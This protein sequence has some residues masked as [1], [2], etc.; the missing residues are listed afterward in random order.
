MIKIGVVEMTIMMIPVII[1]AISLGPVAGGILGGVFGLLSF[2]ECFGKSA[3]GVLL[4][5]I[6]PWATALMCI[7][8]RVLAGMLTGLIF[9]LLKKVD[10]TK[11]ISFGVAGLSGA[12]L[13]TLFFMGSLGLLFWN[14]PEFIS[15]MQS[16]QIPTDNFF[17]LCAAM[18]GTNGII[19]AIVCFVTGSAIAKAVVKFINKV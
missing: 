17:V 14:S 11:L 19:E 1:G 8:P 4:F 9:V 5:E 10:K 6:N 3:F 12:L 7:V 15:T 16:W 18:V 2:Y 13:N